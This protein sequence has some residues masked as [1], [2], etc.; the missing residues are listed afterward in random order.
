MLCNAAR[1][2]LRLLLLAPA[3]LEL[4]ACAP[5]LLTGWWETIGGQGYDG[6]NCFASAR[7]K[8]SKKIQRGTEM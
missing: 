7:K 3:A 2:S 1:Q 6:D 4:A 5:W 8:V